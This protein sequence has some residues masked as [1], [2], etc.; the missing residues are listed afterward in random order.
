MSSKRAAGS[1]GFSLIELMV[2][3]TIVGVL[4][5]IAIP[6]YSNY[7]LRARR[8]EGL[9]ALTQYRQTLERCYSQNFTYVGCP[10]T[11]ITGVATTVCPGPTTTEHGYYTMTCTPIT[12]TTFVLQAKTT[13]SQT[14]DT[15]CDRLT[16]SNNG[17][18]TA[19][20]SGGADATQRCIGSH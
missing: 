1:G 12:A 2:A 17:T 6:S 8:S 11:T 4:A 7:V 9:Q 20:D 10:I 15:G 18:Q 13:G 14:A 3:V 16:V 19:L 5:A